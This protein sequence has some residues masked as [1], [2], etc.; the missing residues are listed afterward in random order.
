MSGLLLFA[1]VLLLMA[2]RQNVIVLL[3]VVATVVHVFLVSRSSTEFLIQ[4]FWFAIDRETLLA[5]P[6]FI[7]AGAVMT[8][9]TIAQRI[10]NVVIAF[11]RPLRGGLALAC[12]V[13]CGA[14][15]AISGSS[16]VTMLAV[17]AILY[18]ALLKEGY[19][20]KLALGSIASAGTLG[21]LIPPS[22][23]LLLYGM[24]TETSVV[25]LF[26]AGV[27]PG[28]LLL[29]VMGAYVTWMNR[30]RPASSFDFWDLMRAL[31]SGGWALMMPVILLGG[32]YSGK[33]S[34]TEA[35]AVSLFYALIVE[36]FVHREM[37]LRDYGT[38]T[39]ATVQ[40]TGIILPIFAIASSLN[41]VVA[42]E[43]VPQQLVAFMKQYIH[44]GW[45]MM[46]VINL[47]LLVI[48]CI[49]EAFSAIIIFA[50][51]FL[52]LIKDYGFNPVHFGII[53]VVNLEIGYLTPP[54]GLNI[55]VGSV[56]FKESFTFMIRAVLPFI[57]LM[58]AALVVI[59]MV[60]P[61]S[62]WLVGAMR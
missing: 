35:A 33:F 51:L 34:P 37:K 31:R 17:G 29:L 21:I 20:K 28:V 58:T 50:P 46:L 30:H 56:A 1:L 8:R 54:V 59:V 40:M 23:P 41:N 47:V 62:M 22:I 3:A 2:L 32:I 42:I 27:G 4:D 26:T 53:M 60:E 44:S 16:V 15:A 38:V 55:I 57:I 14:F 11:T 9:G 19:D 5:I 52:P 25:D 39:L 13:S 24:S 10:I 36:L 12:V 6:M 61:L 45:A 18:P 43:G 48:G 7:L 49:M